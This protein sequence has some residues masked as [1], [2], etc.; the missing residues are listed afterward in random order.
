M[1]NLKILLVDDD[2]FLLAITE[3]SLEKAGYEIETSKT[4]EEAVCLISKYPFDVVITDL[5]LPGDM[6]GIDILEAAKAADSQT[7][8]ILITS[9][10]SV[11]TAVTAM[12]K[13]AA[14][15]LQKPINFDELNLRLEKIR[16][17]KSLVKDASDLR[18]AMDITED[19]ASETI[20][21]L[22]MMVFDLQNELSEVKK[23]LSPSTL[24][25]LRPLRQAQGPV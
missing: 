9:Y 3:K 17:M 12:K 19:K 7:E 2:L 22:E 24:R 16:C 15:Y 18:E 11:D 10:A 25:P 8:V 14:D 5:M 6:D 1:K 23:R 13:G 21:N 4:G 20:R